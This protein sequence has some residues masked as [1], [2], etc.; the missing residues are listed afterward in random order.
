[1]HFCF[2]IFV[3]LCVFYVHICIGC[4]FGVINDEEEEEDDEDEDEDEDDDDED[5]DDD[6]DV[7]NLICSKSK[8][9]SCY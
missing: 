7:I 5:D 3:F 9:Y 8:D 6:D 2:F 4:H 1:V